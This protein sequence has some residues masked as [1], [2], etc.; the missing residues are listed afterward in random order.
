MEECETP[1]A[2]GDNGGVN[3]EGDMTETDEG[4]PG[5]RFMAAA[6]SIAAAVE[7]LGRGEGTA[8]P[9]DIYNGRSSSV[10]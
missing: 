7:E 2:D 8:E 1:L 6:K 10:V 9:V 5:M 3:G 4:E